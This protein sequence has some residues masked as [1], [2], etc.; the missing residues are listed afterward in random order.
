MA[1]GQHTSKIREFAD[2]SSLHTLGFRG[3]ALHSLCTLAKV[4]IVT[5]SQADEVAY[6]CTYDALG[7]CVEEK[8]TSGQTTGTTVVAKSLFYK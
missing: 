7:R 3:E 1:L 6:V 8:P 5:R 2:L 4:S